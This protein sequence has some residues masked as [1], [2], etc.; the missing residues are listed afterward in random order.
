MP[1][2]PVNTITADSGHTPLPPVLNIKK[3]EDKMYSF[4]RNPSTGEITLL[5]YRDM[6]KRAL[7]LAEWKAMAANGNAYSNA[8]TAA[9]YA[10]TVA[11][12]KNK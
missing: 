7:S 12:F 11:K 5:D 10:A 2:I 8:S 4:L 3:V 6:T 9:E 1:I